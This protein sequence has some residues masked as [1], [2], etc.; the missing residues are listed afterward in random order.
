MTTIAMAGVTVHDE[1]VY[2]DTARTLLRFY[3]PSGPT[4]HSDHYISRMIGRILEIPASQAET[5]AEEVLASFS[6]RHPDLLEAFASTARI[7]TEAYLGERHV[8]PAHMHLIVACFTSEISVESAALC[9]PS[10]VPHPDQSGLA[11]GELRVA[12]ATRGIGE[13]HISSI[14]FTEAVIS[15]SSWRF[16]DRRRPLL[17]A[18]VAEGP[19]LDSVEA[20]E[21][22]RDHRRWELARTLLG[23]SSEVVA[24]PLPLP[25]PSRSSRAV[26]DSPV[27]GREPL[28]GRNVPLYRATFGHLSTLSQRVLTPA[29]LDEAHGIEDARFA[30]FRTVS[31]ASE[32]RATYTAF[33]GHRTLPRIIVSPDLRV[34]EIHAARG[35]ATRDKGLAFFP[36]PVNDRLFAL[37]RIGMDS[38]A[39]AESADGTTWETTNTLYRPS[40]WW[41]VAKAGNCGSPIEIDDGWLVITHG[42]GLM[43]RYAI[44]ALLL[45]LHDPTIVRARLPHPILNMAAESP[46]YV[47]NVLYSCGSIVHNDTLWLP[48]SETDDHLRVASFPIESLLSAMTPVRSS[49]R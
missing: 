18:T 14:G 40:A 48:Y 20:A 5:M 1:R 31:G 32:Y 35:S 27:D 44:S 28:T 3:A 4:E 7:L 11:P 22:V 8:S 39:L 34:F 38:I 26:A 41:D 45:D 2:P 19:L 46:G 15:G 6:E 33:D 16:T 10:A 9:N 12:L 17:A 13:G 47:P 37:T 36:R 42:A 49:A 29:L 21:S 30:H 24:T 43:R 25:A 23:E